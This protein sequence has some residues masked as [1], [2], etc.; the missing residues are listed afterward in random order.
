MSL[1]HIMQDLWYTANNVDYSPGINLASPPVAGVIQ[2]TPN[3]NRFI[4]PAVTYPPGALDRY[5]CYAFGWSP[6]VDPT[7]KAALVGGPPAKTTKWYTL[8]RLSHEVSV[9]MG[10]GRTLLLGDDR[11]SP[12]C[13]YLC[14]FSWRSGFK[15]LTAPHV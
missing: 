14:V 2:V 13:I 9:V 11:V 3:A 8:G 5:T 10:D 12:A 6:S 7:P 4:P 15:G 1:L